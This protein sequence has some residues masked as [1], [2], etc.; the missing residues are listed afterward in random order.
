MTAWWLSPL[1]NRLANA[2]LPARIVAG[3]NPYG[4]FQ[5]I[6]RRKLLV[7]ASAIAIVVAMAGIESLQPA[8][9]Q[10][11][12]AA[13]LLVPPP[14]GDRTLGKDDAPV[15]IVEYASMT[16]P[17]CAHFHES[18][19]PELKKRY[20]DT[21]KVRF[22]FREYPLDPLAAGASMLARCADKEQFYP[23]IETLFQ[24]QRQWAVEKPIPQL[25]AIAKQAGMSEQK[26][27][28]CLSDQKMLEA[29]QAEQKRA[30]DKFGVNST[31]TLFINGKKQVGGVSIDDLA[32][33]IDP[34]LPK[35]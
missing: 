14:L 20:I 2:T 29:M 27:N 10:S 11:A 5:V 13:E 18:T 4:E 22:I 30:T 16:C 33:V 17:H 31:P 1:A 28:A 19:Y 15:T 6:T 8:V 24:Q 32:K 34:L 9:A 3:L 21:G 23:L 7:G 25:M 35:S 12:T 26:F